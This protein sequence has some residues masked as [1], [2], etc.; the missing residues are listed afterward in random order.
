MNGEQLGKELPPGVELLFDHME[1]RYYIHVQESNF[2]ARVNPKRHKKY[3]HLFYK[4]S[5]VK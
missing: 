5:G 2:F 3:G 1:R 4:I